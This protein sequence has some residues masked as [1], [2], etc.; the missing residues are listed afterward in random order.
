MEQMVYVKP[1]VSAIENR[2]FGKFV[3]YLWLSII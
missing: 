1:G 3:Y 2:Y